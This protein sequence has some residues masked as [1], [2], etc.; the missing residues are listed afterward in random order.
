M[1][2]NKALMVN[3]LTG[4]VVAPVSTITLEGLGVNSVIDCEGINTGLN[5]EITMGSSSVVAL[6]ASSTIT[7]G[8]VEVPTISSS[9]TLTNKTISG[10]SNTIT[11]ISLTTGITG[12]LGLGNGGSGATTAGG[13]RTA[14]A[15]AKV[16]A[17]VGSLGTADYAGQPGITT[18]GGFYVNLNGDSTWTDDFGIYCTNL[19]ANTFQP[20][21]VF[22]QSSSLGSHRFS[23][24]GSTY[25]DNVI[26]IQSTVDAG[27]GQLGYSAIVYWHPSDTIDNGRGFATGVAPNNSSDYANKA[28]VA[29]NPPVSS[30]TN[31]PMDIL[32]S[33][34]QDNGSGYVTH[35]RVLLD[36]TNK[37]V[38][39]YGWSNTL[40]SGPV[41][42]HVT[43]TGA[44]AVGTST[45]EGS[46][47]LTVSGG[48]ITTWGTG[49]GLRIYPQGGTTASTHHQ[50]HATDANTLLITS[51][52]NG[53]IM[54]YSAV[55]NEW[56]VPYGFMAAGY[57]KIGSGGP[58]WS[59]GSGS[60]EGVVTAPI[61]SLYSNTAGGLLTTLYVKT[62][63][64]GNTGWTAK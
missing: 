8:A 54:A 49:S 56:S 5:G 7:I 39:L 50:I 46:S 19:Y 48:L 10:A 30:A 36:G 26:D 47:F 21:R 29:T 32:L 53:T 33:Q 35:R 11:N 37:T 14:A 25:I 55:A 3:P 24:S 57:F 38:T 43:S 27:G 23:T 41:G 59:S 18:D 42:V 28:Y 6:G 15:G 1:S 64:A 62:S 58:T 22:T 44:S 4:V 16:A 60:P 31:A 34:E 40:A 17:V 20:R 13:F 61:G 2:A 12:T 51:A 9:S 45:L 52:V 63:T